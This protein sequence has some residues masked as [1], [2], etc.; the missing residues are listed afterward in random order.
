MYQTWKFHLGLLLGN[1][2]ET[3][4]HFL[5]GY[6]QVGSDTY[7]APWNRFQPYLVGLMLG[8]VL[9][10]TRGKQIAINPRLN[11]ICWQENFQDFESFSREDLGMCILAAGL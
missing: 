6:A 5:E 8:Y 7:V 10:K 1:I 9:H 4:P 2:P 11:I 3:D